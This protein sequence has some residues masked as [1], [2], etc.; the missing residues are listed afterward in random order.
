[1]NN[2]IR[3]QIIVFPLASS[4]P[5]PDPHSHT[6]LNRRIELDHREIPARRNRIIGAGKGRGRAGL[7]LRSRQHQN[8]ESLAPSCGR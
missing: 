6:L 3:L 2:R 4:R 8:A 7:R 1:M 5:S